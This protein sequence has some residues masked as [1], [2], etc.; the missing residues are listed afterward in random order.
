MRSNTF[1]GIIEKS[2]NI[3]ILVRGPSIPFI[4]GIKNLLDNTFEINEDSFKTLFIELIESES[5]IAIIDFCDDIET[6][7]VRIKSDYNISNDY[8]NVFHNE[9]NSSLFISN[10]VEE[11]LGNTL[12][13]ICTSLNTLFLLDMKKYKFDWVDK[14]LQ[15]FNKTKKDKWEKDN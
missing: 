12:D 13:T 10:K 9:K 5:K 4:V 8:T 3:E 1:I 2:I 11:K 14:K 15:E 7:V 6:Y